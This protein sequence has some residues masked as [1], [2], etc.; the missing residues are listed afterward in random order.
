MDGSVVHSIF[1]DREKSIWIG[2]DSRGLTRLRDGKIKTF[3]AES[4]LPHEY[5]VYMHEDRDKNLRIGTMDGLARFDKGVLSRESMKIEF[6]DA[7]VGPIC[8]D[9]EGNIW[10]GTYGSGLYKM[11]KKMEN[12]SSIPFVTDCSVIPFSHCTVTAREFL[13]EL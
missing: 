11:Q 2:T 10:F 4:G 12:E 3:S 1:E 13:D 6:S 7:V 9:K 5:V 8:E